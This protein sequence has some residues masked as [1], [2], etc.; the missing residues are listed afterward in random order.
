MNRVAKIF[1]SGSGV[2]LT[3]YLLALWKLTRHP[4][5]PR[6]AKLLALFVL[7]YALSPIDLIPD[8]I[9]ILGLLDDI[10]L[11]P[12]G[13]ALVLRMTPKP[14]WEACLREA[15][16]STDKLPRSWRGAIVIAMVWAV[17][18]GAGA[19]WAAGALGWR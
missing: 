12:L 19:W 5:T 18:I 8:F 4:D 13:V 16:T 14:L 2:R 7:A 11:V 9:P 6:G 17:V 3:T 1:K 10:I 15:Q